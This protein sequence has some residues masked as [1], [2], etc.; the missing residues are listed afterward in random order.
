[1]KLNRK[2]LRRLIEAEIVLSDEEMKKGREKIE[3]EG[4]AVGPK[5]L[6]TA[7]AAG[8]TDPDKENFTPEEYAKAYAEQD[9]EAAEHEEGDI[10]DTGGLA[11]SF[12]RKQ[13]RNL[14]LEELEKVGFY[15]KYNYGLDTVSNKTQAH[16]DII[17][18]T[19]LTHVKRKDS[20]LNEVGEVLWHSLKENG[21]INFYDIEWSD[22]T[23]E[24]N[25]PATLLEKIKDSSE[26]VHEAHGV[27][28]HEESADLE[29]KK[30]KKRKKK[31]KTKKR[32]KKRNTYKMFPFMYGFHYDQDHSG[33]GFDGGGDFGGGE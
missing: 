19:W 12:S 20:S 5:D 14:I 9:P 22:G 26:G 11:E 8:S 30:Y 4:G 7:I 10:V 23:V 3:D 1:M 16:D 15:K 29:E 27:K 17:G 28:G 6:G 25:V 21:E 24:T 31:K 33:S 2:E 13:L 18:H 32:A